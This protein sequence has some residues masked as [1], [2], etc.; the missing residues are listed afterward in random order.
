MQDIED[1]LS[2]C[3]LDW[4]ELHEQGRDVVAA[5]LCQEQP[6]LLPELERRIRIL[7]GLGRAVQELN[8]PAQPSAD[9]SSD[10]SVAAPSFQLAGYEILGQLGCGG[11]GVIYKARQLDLGR[12]VALKVIRPELLSGAHAGARFR[13]EAEAIARLQHPNIVQIYDVGEQHGR[14]YFTLE[15]IEGGSL[16]EQLRGTPLSGEHAAQ[17]TQVLAVA[18][19]HAH[20]H[21]IIHR[22]LK[23]G[24]VLLQN[25][26]GRDLVAALDE[27]SSSR[28]PSGIT[29]QRMIPKLTDFGLAKDLENL[30]AQ[31]Q[32][33]MLLGTPSYMAPE[34]TG[35]VAVAISPATDVYG[36]GAILY[37]L[38]TGR[39][40]FRA[41]NPVDTVLQVL[42]D[43]PVPPRRLQPTVSRDLETICL[44]CLEKAPD[45]RYPTAQAL[46]DDLQRFLDKCPVTAR[47]ASL[48][49]RSLKLARRHPVWSV[50][51]LMTLLAT[52]GALVGLESHNV[53]LAATLAISEQRRIAAEQAKTLADSRKAEA[54]RER[55]RAEAHLVKAKMAVQK[56]LISVSDKPEFLR[57]VPHMTE[58]RLELLETAATIVDELLVESSADPVLLSALAQIHRRIGDIQFELGHYAE[59]ELRLVRACDQLQRLLTTQT[60]PAVRSELAAS[61]YGLGKLYTLQDRFPAAETALGEALAISRKLAV[62][63]P[64]NRDYRQIVGIQTVALANLYSRTG[65]T[66]EAEAAFRE[67]LVVEQ[68]VAAAEPGDHQGWHELASTWHCFGVLLTVSHRSEEALVAYREALAALAQTSAEHQQK[69]AARVLLAGIHYSLGGELQTQRQGEEAERELRCAEQLCRQLADDFPTDPRRQHQL[70]QTLNSLSQ[71]FQ[72]IGRPEQA[73]PLDQESLKL[74][75]QLAADDPQLRSARY[76]LARTLSQRALRFVHEGQRKSAGDY[77]EE[78]LAVLDALI[79]DEPAHAD[80]KC[81]VARRSAI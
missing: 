39:P 6:E 31:T 61:H 54:E 71:L 64:D 4:Q 7:Q 24:N 23:P 81:Y 8:A 45:K 15:L 34:Q 80:Y 10:E 18:I 76:F 46:A 1:F 48:A 25:L 55:Q 66:T 19:Q 14:P 13:T 78:C 62:E 69:T 27:S 63:F 65:R 28:S 12:L 5:Q 29:P 47:P 67:T 32:S 68:T 73:E 50:A 74:L 52:L 79:R 21:G 75:R 30:Q 53:K 42:A 41:P 22:D 26:G 33:G 60:S 72:T 3:L 59:A 51:L 2:E 49:E 35:H 36:L 16:A 20:D 56:L 70:A 37:E 57:D 44:K 43:E 11:M 40:P 9:G 17:L 77:W 58:L 38:L